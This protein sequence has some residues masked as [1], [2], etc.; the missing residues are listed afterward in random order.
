MKMKNYDSALSPLCDE[1][2]KDGSTEFIT[3]WFHC[4]PISSR[5]ASLVY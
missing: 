3:Q 1:K 4:D 5:S 2:M